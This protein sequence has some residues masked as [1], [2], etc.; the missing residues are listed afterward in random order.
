MRK[1]PLLLVVALLALAGCR[2]TGPGAAAVPPPS[3]PL[4]EV[5]RDCS[6]SGGRMIALGAMQMCLHDTRDAGKAC[7]RSSDCEGDCLARSGTC[8]PARP[9][10]G[11]HEIL[12]DQG[13]RAM[14]CRG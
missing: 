14:Q 2:E 6:R 12:L 5:T 7:R 4:A 13:Q 9:M 10:S 8:A 1:A 3:D 11:C